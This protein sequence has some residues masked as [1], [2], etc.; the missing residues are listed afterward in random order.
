MHSRPCYPGRDIRLRRVRPGLDAM[1]QPPT[2]EI[3]CCCDFK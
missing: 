3:G 2:L 1:T